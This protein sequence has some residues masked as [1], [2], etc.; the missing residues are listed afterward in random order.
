VGVRWLASRRP[1]ALATA[2]ILVAG[3]RLIEAIDVLTAANRERRNAALERRLLDL[4]LRAFETLV[5]AGSRVPTPA[6][7]QDAAEHVAGLPEESV[8]GLTVARVRDAIQRHGSLIVRG[9]VPESRTHA[10]VA[11]IDRLFA[12]GDDWTAWLRRSHTGM[13][14]RRWNRETGA[15]LVADSPETMFDLI[16]LFEQIGLRDLMTMYFGERPALLARKWTLRRVRHDAPMGDWHQDGAFLGKDIRSLNVWISL[17]CC[18]ID[19]PG[20]EI[21]GRRLHDI[22]QTGTD[23]AFFDWSVGHGA[24]ARCGGPIVRPTFEPGD[25]LFFDHMNLHRTVVE[26]TMVRDRYAIESWFM[27]PSSYR[28]MIGSGKRTLTGRSK[29]HLPIVF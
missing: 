25:A 17:S 7:A 23:G 6:H 12:A 4:R 22:V 26:P 1:A 5:T 20:L 2:D 14:L 21:V 3:G 11:E 9:L 29:G 28:A 13:R 15:F 8:N 27:A 24:V 18:G 19:A 10:L 16:E